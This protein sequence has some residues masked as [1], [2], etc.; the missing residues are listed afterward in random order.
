MTISKSSMVEIL[1]VEDNMA[2][3]RL[4]KEAFRDAKVLNNMHVVYDG[5]E[6]MS[7]LEARGQIC[8]RPLP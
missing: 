7:F 8:R 5:E 4:T 1:M 6:A 3:V 2:D